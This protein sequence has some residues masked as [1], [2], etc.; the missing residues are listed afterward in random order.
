MFIVPDDGDDKLA[1]L[2]ANLLLLIGNAVEEEAKQRGFEY[3]NLYRYRGGETHYFSFLEEVPVLLAD[4]Q[5]RAKQPKRQQVLTAG[6]DKYPNKKQRI[7]AL[8][9]DLEE[10]FVLQGGQPCYP[11]LIQHP[12]IQALVAEGQEAVEPLLVCLESDTRLTRTIYYFRDFF[13]HRRILGVHEAAYVALS[14]IL[15]T[16]FFK[17]F[18]RAHKLYSQ[19]M[20]GR[21]EV[22]AKI[23]EY[24]KLNLIRKTLYRLKHR[25]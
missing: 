9:E 25:F 19:G 12:I 24:L 5:R 1:L 21:Q 16:S 14:A 17:R 6:L 10:V 11:S 3:P 20:E 22:A 7:S 8:I 18:E 15:K 23:R 13:Q 4:Q 2:S